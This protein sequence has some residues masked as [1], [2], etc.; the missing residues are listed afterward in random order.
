MPQQ[1]P[2]V[3]SRI[4][5]HRYT[6][7][8][9]FVIDNPFGDHCRPLPFDLTGYDGS[10]CRPILCILRLV[11]FGAILG[12]LGPF[13]GHLGHGGP[14]WGHLEAKRACSTCS[15]G[16]G[17]HHKQQSSQPHCKHTHTHAHTHTHTLTHGGAC[18]CAR[19]D[20]SASTATPHIYPRVCVSARTCGSARPATSIRTCSRRPRSAASWSR[21]TALSCRPASWCRPVARPPWPQQQ[22]P[23][24]QHQTLK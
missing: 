8:G 22:Q 19:I 2:A 9:G 5:N 15:K 4:L 10:T 20:R 1:Q 24:Q 11:C 16:Q 17:T 3:A 6:H 18:E 14:S 7:W 21:P 23:Q 12:I 13:G